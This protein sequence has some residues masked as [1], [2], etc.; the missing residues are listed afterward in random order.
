MVHLPALA[1][2]ST[3]QIQKLINDT[4]QILI[5]GNH[6]EYLTLNGKLIINSHMA[7]GTCNTLYVEPF[8]MDRSHALNGVLLTTSQEFTILLGFTHNDMYSPLA[9]PHLVIPWPISTHSTNNLLH[10][11]MLCTSVWIKSGLLYNID[12]ESVEVHNCCMTD[13]I[14]GYTLSNKC[15]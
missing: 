2:S 14:M 11:S 10:L 5:L 4:T 1:L 3:I 13:N 8:M 12:D 7:Y 6:G 9:A 15:T